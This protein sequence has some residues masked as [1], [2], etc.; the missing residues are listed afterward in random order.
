MSEFDRKIPVGIQSFPDI[1][2]NQYMYVDKTEYI[3]KLVHRGKPYF[4]SRPRRFGK[5]LFLSTLKAYWE[6]KKELFK[7]LKIE[8]LEKNNPDAW[9]PYPVFYFDF[10]R[11]NYADEFALEGVLDDHLKKW[12]SVYGLTGQDGSL[13]LRFQNLLV[14]AYNKEK[15]RCVV[16]VDEY[17]KS[18]LES[19][20]NST[21]HEKNKAV[22]K[23]F[24][25]TLKS[26]DGYIRFV[27]ITGVTKF[28]KV[29][30]FSDMN[31]LNDI[32]FE[33][34]YSGI[35]GI[36]EAEMKAN[37]QPEIEALADARHFTY[38]ECL[39]R[40][41]NMYDGYRFSPECA[42][43]YNP[44]SLLSALEKRRFGA[45]WFQTGTPT[46]LVRKLRELNFDVR[47]FDERTIQASESVLSD[48]RIENPD[49]IP[50]FYQTGCLTIKGYT[51]YIEEVLY[52][53]GFPNR[54]VRYAFLECLL[55]A[56]VANY[57]PGSGK[58]IFTLNRYIEAGNVEGIRNVFSALFAS[59]PY[60]S[61]DAPFEH[62]FQTITF[63]VF[64]LLG[65]YT[66][67]EMHTA[68][69]R[70]D[71]VVETANFVYIFEFK[72]DKSADEALR[73]IEEK[74]YAKAYEA[75]PRQLF[76]IGANFDSETRQL[77]G[78]KTVVS[79]Q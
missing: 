20:E 6:G 73:Q 48:Y 31:Q 25:S 57:G 11:D 76:L 62:Y 75:D 64:T 18:L 5:S 3:Y 15:K 44:F 49:P 78:W 43:I 47:Q 8:E 46:F 56:Y 67:C 79:G 74:Q 1:I 21:L 14:S 39:Q 12:E 13:A 32:S 27:F 58:D 70:I 54:E 52:T 42:D 66:K 35:C 26:F 22:F 4:L 40:L 45:F 51:D 65:K 55:P 9:Q 36:T 16:L 77:E 38:E 24:F 63:I 19:T 72:R 37:F 28:S 34:K 59:I 61:N 17:D 41:K 23:G 69:G 10:N 2:E 33:D 7:G 50:L 30:I 60:T 29:G 71:C 53:L 68:A